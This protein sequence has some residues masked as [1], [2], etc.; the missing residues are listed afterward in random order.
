MF[1]N[2]FLKAF[3]IPL[4][5]PGLVV[6]VTLNAWQNQTTACCIA[7]AGLELKAICVHP[8]ASAMSVMNTPHSC[9]SGLNL[10]L[11]APQVCV[12][13]LNALCYLRALCFLKAGA[14]LNLAVQ[15][16][17]GPLTSTPSAGL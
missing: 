13:P 7:Q 17:P 15:Q 16:A 11:H 10:A 2:F 6:E 9:Y 12:L 5:S 4:H 1:Y 3:L 14:S 8:I